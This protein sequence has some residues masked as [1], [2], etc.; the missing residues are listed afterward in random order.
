MTAIEPDTDRAR[1]VHDESI[2]IDCRDP[3]F[4]LYRQT[5][6]EKPDYWDT[7][8]ASGLTAIMVDV[9]WTEDGFRDAS[10]NFAAWHE[11]IAAHPNT[12]VVRQAS[13]IVTAK[14]QRRIGFILSSQTPTI[15]ENDLL[16]LR[17]LYEQ[18]LR[19]MEMTYQK[20][21]LLADGCAERRGAGLTAFGKQAVG[22]MNRLG[23][24]IDLSHASD[25]T[26]EETIAE[27]VQPVFFSHSNA[28]HQVDHARN[29]PD[30]T[31]R[32][33]AERGGLC[34]ISAYSAF[35]RDGGGSSGTGLSDY[36]AMVNYVVDLIGIDHVG[37][38]FDVGESRTSQEAILIGGGNPKLTHDPSTRYVRELMTRRRLPML[39]EARFNTGYDDDG[40]RK[41]LGGNVL[42][43]FE[44][45]W[46]PAARHAA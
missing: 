27:S 17:A 4:L 7:I 35:L 8:A 40:V 11:R 1:R 19:V 46:A 44:R 33:L 12:M 38:G 29:V 42:R 24:A 43:F 25:R 34:C 9:P 18:G 13:D 28:R 31:L 14:E 3:T 30:A 32:E 22:E 5:R 15:I 2:I 21:N 39:T 10:L 36:V 37:M 26:M 6:D 20:A 45:V 41:F 16:L 23:I